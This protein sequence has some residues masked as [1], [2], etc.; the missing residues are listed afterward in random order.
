M[1]PH[2]RTTCFP[3][4]ATH[5]NIYA[6]PVGLRYF[7]GGFCPLHR[8]RPHHCMR[9]TLTFIGSVQE[10]CSSAINP[11]RFRTQSICDLTRR[12]GLPTRLAPTHR[13]EFTY[14]AER[15]AHHSP[16]IMLMSAK[17]T[18]I[19]KNEPPA[20][21]EPTTLRLKAECSSQLSYGSASHFQHGIEFILNPV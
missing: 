18:E 19:R 14:K 5:Y 15:K 9:T 20:G 10:C 11:D 21:L 7:G 1:I 16:K 8:L 4:N 17:T 12:E 13:V 2:L 6:T 3:P